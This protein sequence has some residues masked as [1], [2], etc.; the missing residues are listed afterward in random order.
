MRSNVPAYLRQWR[1][2]RGRHLW[3]ERKHMEEKG[4][5]HET[6]YSGRNTIIITT[7]TTTTS[8]A[9]REPSTTRPESK[10]QSAAREVTGGSARRG[11][12]GS[13]CNTLHIWKFG[14]LSS[15]YCWPQKH[16][17][18][19]FDREQGR[20]V[21]LRHL[22][23]FDAAAVKLRWRSIK[24]G[25]TGASCCHHLNFIQIRWGR[26]ISYQR[27]WWRRERTLCLPCAQW[28]P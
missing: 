22:Y 1:P 5:R 18:L 24:S 12:G 14:K 21:H 28:A 6:H 27:S 8:A 9:S 19:S 10:T 11:Q 26:D 16:F 3:R 2:E 4:E 20:D 23:Q 15:H 17:Q 13:I 7:T 25:F